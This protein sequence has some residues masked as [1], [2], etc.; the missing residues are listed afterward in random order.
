M[1]MSSPIEGQGSYYTSLDIPAFQMRGTV[2]LN[3]FGHFGDI[4]HREAGIP[5]QAIP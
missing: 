5:Q 1:T 2:L 3:K 4:A